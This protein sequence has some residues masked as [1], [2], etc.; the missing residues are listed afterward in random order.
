MKKKFVKSE[1]SIYAWTH[2][3]QNPNVVSIASAVFTGFRL[4][5]DRQTS[6]L[7]STAPSSERPPVRNAP[8]LRSVHA[9]A[10]TVQSEYPA[11][12]RAAA[13]VPLPES[14]WG[15]T[16]KSISSVSFV[17]IESK[18]YNTQETQTQKSDAPEF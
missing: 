9:A 17:Q 3:S 11:E 5:T 13:A 8:E 7:L 16:S 10:L 2:P 18:F 12:R 6:R 15:Q 14:P 1:F 4:V